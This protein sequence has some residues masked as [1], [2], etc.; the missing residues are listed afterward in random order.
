MALG[1]IPQECPQA[2][3]RSRRIRALLAAS[4]GPADSSPRANKGWYCQDA[5]QRIILPINAQSS[6][7]EGASSTAVD[8]SVR[9]FDLLR[10]ASCL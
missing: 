3:P 1:F 7:V 9:A 6:C 4:D 10:L 5:P 2:R 8:N